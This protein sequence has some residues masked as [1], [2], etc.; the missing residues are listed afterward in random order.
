[1]HAP[2]DLAARARRRRLL[3]SNELGPGSTAAAFMW[4]SRVC[5]L[6]APR[7]GGQVWR[8]QPSGHREL[9]IDGLRWPINGVTFHL[10]RLYIAEGGS[11]GRISYLDRAGNHVTV[12]DD[13]PGPGNYHT[14]MVAAGPDGKLYFSQGAMT[15]TG[16]VGLDAYELGWLRRLPHAHDMPGHALVLSGVNVET[17]DPLGVESRGPCLDRRVRT[18][19]NADVAWT[20]N[21]SAASLHLGDP[22]VRRRRPRPRARRVGTAQRLRV[23]LSTG[24]TTAGRR[25]G[26][27]RSGQPSGRERAGPALR[28]SDRRLVRLARLHRR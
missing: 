21:R 3:V 10:D 17:A 18:V 16:I 6:A 2:R 1:M 14:N 22:A 4:P 13:L 19:R 12:L 27:R 15:N 25:S 5:R 28:S 9:L 8:V 23:G 7:A 26:R 24:W 20:A 11:P